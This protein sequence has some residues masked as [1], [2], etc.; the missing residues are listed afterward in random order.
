MERLTNWHALWEELS[1]MQNIAFA[2]QKQRKTDDFWEDKAKHYDKMVDERWSAPD[3][4]REFLIQTLK[5]NPG[6]TLLDV[7]AGTG[8]WS[9]LASPYAAK[10]TALEPSSAM[11]QVFRRKIEN[12][13]ITNIDIVTGTWPEDD[14]GPHDYILSS[15]SIYGVR[16]FKAFVN[17]MSARATR[18]CIMILRVPLADSVMAEAARHV[19]SQPYDSPNFQIAYNLLLGMDIY[20]DIIMEKGGKWPPWNHD[21]FEEALDDLKNRLGLINS[22]VDSLKHDAFLSGLLEKSLIREK[23]KYVWPTGNRSALVYWEV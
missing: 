21:S 13:K 23:G 2:R 12:E 9:M 3:S 20:P 10:V 4:S 14:V 6:S 17:K 22:S 18:G 1:D 19:L 5:D 15:H 16:D 7:G 11:Q 8:K